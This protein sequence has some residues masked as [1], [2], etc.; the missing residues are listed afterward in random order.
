MRAYL[1]FLVG[2]PG[3]G[4]LTVGRQIVE[5]LETAG[6]EVRLVDNHYVNNPIFRLVDADGVTPLP[7]EVWEAVSAVR[8]A[9]IGTIERL[10]PSHW[11]FVLT[12]HI[13]DS[14]GDRAWVTR[15]ETIATT[16]GSHFVPVRLLCDVEELERRI[17][18]PDRVPHMKSIDPLEPRR[19]HEGPGVPLIDHPATLT[20]DITVMAPEH[21][22]TRI[23]EHAERLPDLA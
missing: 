4:K 11:T 20:L 21:A 14:P 2:F 9:V 13:D 12:N 1:F 5:Q 15:L 3:T 17:V 6:R 8:E 16:R 18:S 23:I 10:S 19:L 7:K 22:A